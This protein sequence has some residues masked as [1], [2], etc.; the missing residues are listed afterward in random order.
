M[1]LADEE[2][3]AERRTLHESVRN[4]RTNL[5]VMAQ[6]VFCQWV[7]LELSVHGLF[8]ERVGRVTEALRGGF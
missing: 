3:I 2:F 1:H 5:P 4:E 6:A 7:G 8:P